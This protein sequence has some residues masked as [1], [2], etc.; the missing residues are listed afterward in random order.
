MIFSL[1]ALQANQGDSLILHFGDKDAPE[2]AVIDGGPATIYKKS[3]QKRLKE[4]AGKFSESSALPIALAMVSHIDDDHIHGILDWLTDDDPKCQ[5]GDFW[6]NSFSDALN[7]IPPE[8]RT[9]SLGGDTAKAQ[10]ASIK[11]GTNNPYVKM[12]VAS[13]DQGRN[14]RAFLEKEGIQ[15]N[16]DREGLLIADGNKTTGVFGKLKLT[17]VAPNQTRLKALYDEWQKEL[18]KKKPKM[19]P[20][21]YVDLSVTNLSSLVVVAECGD[22]TMLLTGDARGDHIMDGLRDAKFI[23]DDKFHV[24]ILKV[25]HHGSN[26]D[27]DLDFFQ[28]VTADHYVISADGKYDNP[29]KEV[30]CWIAQARGDKAKYTV[31]MTNEK[32]KYPILS[33]NIAAACKKFPKLKDKLQFRDPKALSLRID[34]DDAVTY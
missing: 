6:F 20:T 22:F 25:P 17:V 12:I 27:L 9:A 13:V 23:K 19:K 3:L 4:I 2:F 14:L 7:H 16:G 28:T 8:L 32:S 26:R 5:I 30:L 29:D 31:H 11:A 21:A 34:L 18:K 33:K 24:D 15:T 10:M 1:E